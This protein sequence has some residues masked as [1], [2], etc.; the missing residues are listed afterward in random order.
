LAGSPDVSVVVP[1]YNKAEYIERAISSLLKQ[2]YPDFEVV[3]VDDGSTDGGADI[4]TEI[5]EPRVRMVRQ[6][7][8]GEGAARNRGIR[9]SRG[10]LIAMLDADDEWDPEFLESVVALAQRFPD[11][12]IYATGYRSVYRGGLITETSLASDGSDMCIRVYDYFKKACVAGFVWSSAQAIPRFVY[13]KVG[14]FDEATPIGID[15]DMWGRIALRYPVAYDCVVRA[16]YRNDVQGFRMVHAYKKTLAF[17]PFV[18]SARAAIECGLVR[19][20]V[21]ADLREYVNRLLLQ[22]V[23]RAIA[24]GNRAELRRVLRGEL[25][26]TEALKREVIA[27]R[28]ASVAC[29]MSLLY[30]MRRVLNSRWISFARRQRLDSGVVRRVVS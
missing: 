30:W 4:V 7:N 6:E 23:D 2:T 17:P 8:K 12:G 14:G 20:E 15:L 1:L 18:R 28:L 10:S 3:V 13:D 26:P 16:S 9:E 29:P 21:T 22:Y 27:L 24:A 11:A 25:Y 19:G 5:A